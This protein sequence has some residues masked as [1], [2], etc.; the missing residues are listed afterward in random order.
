MIKYVPFEFPKSTDGEYILGLDDAGILKSRREQLGLTIKQVA[1]MAGVQF[2]LYQRLEAGERNISGCSMRVGL[3]ICAVLLLD[4]CEI[5]GVTVQQPCLKSLKPQTTFS[6]DFMENIQNKVG[7]KQIRRDIMC[8]YFNHPFYSVI[9][10]REVLQAIGSPHDIEFLWNNEKKQLLLHGVDIPYKDSF[11]VPPYTYTECTAL[12][13]PQTKLFDEAKTALGW[14]N[15]VYSVECKIV[16]DANK[17][18]YF[19]FDL[20]NGHHSEKISGPYA[21]PLKFA[22][23][24]D[25]FNDED[26]DDISDEKDI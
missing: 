10:P 11:D 15:N 20:K 4:P 1:D 7:R 21:S 19:L 9:I 14:D 13:I 6:A 25:T 16:L 12:V 17:N 18:K 26:T 3:A 23:E 2:S 8:V 5:V 22:D 24:D